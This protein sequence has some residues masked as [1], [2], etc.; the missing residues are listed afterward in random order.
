MGEAKIVLAITLGVNYSANAYIFKHGKTED[1]NKVFNVPFNNPITDELVNNTPTVALFNDQNTFDSYG[2]EALH[3]YIHHEN[4]SEYLIFREFIW[5]LF[6]A[7]NLNNDEQVPENL[8]TEDGRK[9]KA[10]DVMSAVLRYMASH[11]ISI[12]ADES[13]GASFSFE[14]VLTLP[15]YSREDSRRFMTEAAVKAGFLSNNVLIV[16][17]AAAALQFCLHNSFDTEH[18][19]LEKTSNRKFILVEWEDYSVTISILH[20]TNEKNIDI[21]YRNNNEFWTSSEAE[22]DIVEMLCLESGETLL[23]LFIENYPLEYY[24]LLHKVKKKIRCEL[25]E[26]QKVSIKMSVFMLEKKKSFQDVFLKTGLKDKIEFK[27]DKCIISSE[28]FQNLFTDAGKRV[29]NYLKY[30][31]C[32]VIPNMDYVIVV[33]EFAQSPTLQDIM[34]TSLPAKY[35]FIPEDLNIAVVRGATLIGQRNPSLMTRILD[36]MQRSS[37]DAQVVINVPGKTNERKKRC[38]IR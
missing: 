12:T 33:G 5:D 1:R 36:K 24:E 28:V 32:G 38:V 8:V 20:Y 13:Q 31:L 3:K 26:S 2:F 14:Y 29:V 22:K 27:Q 23:D 25:P 15:T 4:M 6:C 11:V 18:Q 17:E 34:R 30:E 37:N 9:M 16:E 7:D 21:V 19:L 10:I 35:I